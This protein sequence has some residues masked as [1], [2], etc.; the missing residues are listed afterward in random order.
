MDV[1]IHHWE[2]TNEVDSKGY[3]ILKHHTLTTLRFF[4]VS[5]LELAGFNHQNV[6]WELEVSRVAEPGLDSKFSVDMPTSFGCEASF[7]CNRIR[8]L[9]AVPY[10]KR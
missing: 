8:V 2:M 5:D 10:T 9:S 7:K 4:R 6:L 3:F 1:A